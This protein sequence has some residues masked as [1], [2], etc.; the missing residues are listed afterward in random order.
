MYNVAY[1]ASPFPF[2]ECQILMDVATVTAELAG[3]IEAWD[4]HEQ[5]PMFD[6][7]LLKSC[8]EAGR[9]ITQGRSHS[10]KKVLNRPSSGFLMA[11]IRRP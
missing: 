11:A 2:T 6:A 7:F 9:D 3:C 10:I 8:K 1:G 4:L 5:G